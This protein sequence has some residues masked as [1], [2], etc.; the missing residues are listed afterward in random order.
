[1]IPRLFIAAFLLAHGSIHASFLAKRPPA[2]AGGPPWPFDLSRSWVLTPLGMQSELTRLVGIGLVAATI[3]SFAFAA[4]AAAGTVPAGLWGPATATGAIA[5]AALLGLFF[6][7]TLALGVLIDLGLLWVV[8]IAG[9]APDAG[10]L[11]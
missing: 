10:A 3:A 9:W 11:P 1:M 6:R 8:V 7:P 5:S 4:V 2:T